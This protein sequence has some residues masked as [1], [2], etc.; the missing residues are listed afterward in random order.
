MIINRSLLSSMHVSTPLLPSA[1]HS[2]FHFVDGVEVEL[3]FAAVD[4]LNDVVGLRVIV[5]HHQTGQLTVQVLAQTLTHSCQH[6]HTHWIFIREYLQATLITEHVCAQEEEELIV[7][8]N[9]QHPA[10]HKIGHFSPL[11]FICVCRFVFE[12]LP[13]PKKSV[14]VVYVVTPCPLLSSYGIIYVT[15]YTSHQPE[16]TGITARGPST[17]G[18]PKFARRCFF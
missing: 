2:S 9:V 4:A 16:P 6:R 12:R 8:V 11:L 10:W 3:L 13:G 5:Q 15:S 17:V 7:W 1:Y 18:G 14:A